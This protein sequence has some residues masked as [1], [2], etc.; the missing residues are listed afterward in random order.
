MPL[1]VTWSAM[2]SL[3]YG[4]PGE[5]AVN[6]KEEVALK[7]QGQYW[8]RRQR[9]KGAKRTVCNNGLPVQCWV[10]YLARVWRICP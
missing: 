10:G 6:K 4:T 8:C 2:G 9:L 3:K 5:I 7:V 1:T